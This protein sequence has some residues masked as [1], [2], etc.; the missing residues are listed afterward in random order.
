M[1]KPSTEEIIRRQIADNPVIIYMKGSPEAPECGFSA[2]AIAA[3]NTTSA[4]LAFV[5]VLQAPFIRER[6]PKVSGWPTFPQLFVNGEL[7]GGSD[8][9][10]EMIDSGELQPLLQQATAAA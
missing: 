1:N 10:C 8:I 2:K 7:I 4:D 6:L 3:L 9:I 5:N